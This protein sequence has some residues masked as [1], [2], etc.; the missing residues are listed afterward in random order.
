MRLFVLTAASMLFAGPVIGQIPAGGRAV[1]KIVDPS[2]AYV[3]GAVVRVADPDAGVL[4]SQTVA[5]RAGDFRTE[6]LKPGTYL[7]VVS[8]QGFGASRKS[9]TIQQSQVADVGAIR[10]EVGSCDDPGVNC[11]EGMVVPLNS[12]P[13]RIVPVIASGSRW[14][15]LDC[16]LDLIGG[17]VRCQ[18]DAA[19]PQSEP[20]TDDVYLIGKDG[21]IYLQAVNG[22]ALSRPNPRSKN[23]SEV[24][25]DQTVVRLDGMGHGDDLCVRLREGRRSHILPLQDIW[26]NS[27]QVNLAYVTR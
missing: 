20:R 22:A 4:V 11:D 9:V 14:V 7:F 13:I 16:G 15:K 3:P 17:N 26:R 5:D 8:A 18:S 2:E 21:G 10:L 19:Q 25:F 12:A 6:I 24:Q 23:C 27:T 1:G